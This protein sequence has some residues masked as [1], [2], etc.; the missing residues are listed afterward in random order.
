VHRAQPLDKLA[1]G[2][3]A[4]AIRIQEAEKVQHAEAHLAAAQPGEQLCQEG[5][6]LTWLQVPLA[7]RAASVW[8]VAVAH[9]QCLGA[10]LASHQLP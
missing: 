9:E 10:H 8:R 1:K 2:D 6:H 4:V 5:A 7:R 3:A